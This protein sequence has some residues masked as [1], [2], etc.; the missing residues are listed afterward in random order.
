MVAQN[1]H[2]SKVPFAAKRIARH[3]SHSTVVAH[4]GTQTTLGQ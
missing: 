1:E 4:H 3:I 2:Q